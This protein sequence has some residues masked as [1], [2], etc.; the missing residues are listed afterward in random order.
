MFRSLADDELDA[1][2]CLLASEVPDGLAVDRL[3]YDE[4][5]AA[6][7]PDQ[8]PTLPRVTVAFAPLAGA[9]AVRCSGTRRVPRV[10]S[11]AWRIAL[12]N[13]GARRSA[14]SRDSS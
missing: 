1:A 7:A 10:S 14:S 12:A 5:V 13:A 3:S 4:V 2:F 11:P 9:G 6:F 8:A